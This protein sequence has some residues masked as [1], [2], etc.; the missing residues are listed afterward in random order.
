MTEALVV[1]TDIAAAPHELAIRDV[2]AASEKVHEILTK[3]MVKDMHY[4]VIPGTPRPSLYKP[5]AEKIALTF[6]LVPAY[7]VEDLS[8]PPHYYRYRVTCE[9]VHGPTGTPVGSAVREASTDEEKWRWRE[10][11]SAAEWDATP[12]DR[13]RLK[14]KRGEKDGTQQVLRDAPDMA[15]TA[16]AMAEK[17]AFVGAVKEA[18]AASDIFE[19]MDSKGREERPKVQQPKAKAKVETAPP[20]T[21]TN[22]EP[23]PEPGYEPIIPADAWTEIKRSLHD[24]GV[25][26]EGQR[27]RLFAIAI[28]EGGW[29]TNGVAAEVRAGLGREVEA[30]NFGAPYNLTVDLF[31]TYRPDAGAAE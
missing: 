24:G 19:D 29:S 8:A 26:S 2:V 17:R 6:R 13:K 15:P 28:N 16:L 21:A 4:G 31:K 10:P 23:P 30:I 20:P 11:V 22:S 7:R 5:G 27:K 18:T 1:P 9:L 3:V 25:I 14:F 12:G